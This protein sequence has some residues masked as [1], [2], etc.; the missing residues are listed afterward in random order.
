[1]IGNYFK[2]MW[3][4]FEGGEEEE[5]GGEEINIEWSELEKWKKGGGEKE[6]KKVRRTGKKE[7]NGKMWNYIKRET[8]KQKKI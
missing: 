3:F 6:R 8:R 2:L 5:E 4:F 1:M 7:R